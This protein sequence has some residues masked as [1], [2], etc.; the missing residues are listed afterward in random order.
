MFSR[1]SRA[2]EEECGV[3]IG[4][5]APP[6]PPFR[7]PGWQRG[8]VAIHSD[9]GRRYVSNDEGGVD[10]TTP[11]RVGETVGVGLSF[12][13]AAYAAG[14]SPKLEMDVVV[15]KDGRRVAGWNLERQSDAA[16]EHLEGL[17]G[18]MDLFPAIGVF[19][20]TEVEVN[21]GEASWLYRG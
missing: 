9:D 14:R 19:G 13:V 16:V 10:C 20:E 21:Y 17:R 5:F 18:E 7:L 4:F 1:S 15:S 8:S 12:S 11:F 2:A 6:Y 3:A